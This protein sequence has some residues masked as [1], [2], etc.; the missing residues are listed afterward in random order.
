MK[1]VPLFAARR[2]PV[3]LR[4]GKLYE[5]SLTSANSAGGRG[6]EYPVSLSIGRTS[7]PGQTNRLL[8]VKTIQE[9]SSSS[10]RR[11]LVA[12]GISIASS[13]LDGVVWVIGNTRTAG[14]PS[15]TW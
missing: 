7:G 4:P 15:S 8:S 1:P 10:P 11:R 3:P 5:P 2:R 13:A 6:P 9:R 12:G 14:V